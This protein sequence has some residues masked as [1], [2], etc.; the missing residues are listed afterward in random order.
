MPVVALFLILLFAS[1]L[2]EVEDPFPDKIG[3]SFVFGGAGLGGVMAG[4]FFAAATPQKRER[5]MAM[6]NLAGFA[7]AATYYLIALFI[8]VI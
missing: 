1:V 6:G 7:L 8:Q 3:L 4:V 5:A 2:P